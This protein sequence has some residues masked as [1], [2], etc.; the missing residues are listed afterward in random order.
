MTLYRKIKQYYVSNFFL[1]I[2]FCI[3]LLTTIGS[4]GAYFI[5][6]KGMS[7]FNFMQLVVCVSGAMAYLTGVLGQLKKE[8]TFTI[9]SIALLVEVLLVAGNLIYP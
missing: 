5:T 3:I 6:I 7:T 8:Y 9:L 4:F 2:P 1:M